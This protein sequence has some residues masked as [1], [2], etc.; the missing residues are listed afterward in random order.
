MRLMVH[1]SKKFTNAF[2][3]IF[4]GI[5]G[6][7]S[8]AVH[9]PM[10]L[11]VCALAWWLGCDAWQWCVLLLCVGMV[12]SLELMNSA[13]ESLA[14]G[15]CTEHNERVGRALDMASG[16]VLVASLVAVIIGLIVLGGQFLQ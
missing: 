2:F 12:I 10:T 11:G 4:Q 6:Q 1:W 14:K 16:A 9:L 5:R 8:F 7:S 15:L 13:L 3:G